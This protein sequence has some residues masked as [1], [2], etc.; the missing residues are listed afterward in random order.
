[1][2]IF[3]MQVKISYLARNNVFTFLVN[4]DTQISTMILILTY[5]LK[6]ISQVLGIE[7][8]VQMLFIM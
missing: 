5:K 7:F 4:F 6:Q 8:K 1:M 2:F 3:A